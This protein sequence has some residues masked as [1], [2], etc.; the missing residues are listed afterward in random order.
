MKVTEFPANEDSQKALLAFLEGK[1]SLPIR[2][3]DSFRG[4][5]EI[6]KTD[7]SKKS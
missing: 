4:L 7:K 6:L 3:E 2:I 5:T 1:Q